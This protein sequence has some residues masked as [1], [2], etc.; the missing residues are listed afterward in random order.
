MTQIGLR[1]NHRERTVIKFYC[2]GIYSFACNFSTMTAKRRFFVHEKGRN[3][4]K[5]PSVSKP[6]VAFCQARVNLRKIQ[7]SQNSISS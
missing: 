7:P 2:V 5:K 3:P 4:N 1:K 6:L